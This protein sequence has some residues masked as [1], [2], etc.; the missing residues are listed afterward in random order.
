MFFSYLISYQKR[1]ENF[2]LDKNVI[3]IGKNN[4]LFDKFFFFSI[5]FSS[6]YKKKNLMH[7]YFFDLIFCYKGWRFFKQLPVNGQRTWTNSNTSNILNISSKVNKLNYYKNILGFSNLSSINSFLLV[8]YYNLLWKLQW[9]DEWLELRK[10]KLIFLKK[11]SRKEIS[12]TEEALLSELLYLRGRLLKKKVRVQFKGGTSIL[13][14]E[15]G[16]FLNYN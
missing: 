10:N 13:G 15:P 1:I 3:Y 12:I 16:L 5:N 4:F 14:F 2:L 6:N 11:K 8:E 7:I 9:E